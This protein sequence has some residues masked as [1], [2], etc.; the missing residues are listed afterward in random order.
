VRNKIGMTK[1][2]PCPFLQTTGWRDN[3]LSLETILK[4]G[5]TVGIGASVNEEIIFPSGQTTF[6]VKIPGLHFR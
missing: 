6:H 4:R 3:F 2:Q 1:I 5:E